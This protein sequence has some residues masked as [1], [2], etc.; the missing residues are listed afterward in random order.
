MNERGSLRAMVRLGQAGWA[1]MGAGPQSDVDG[2][3]TFSL[4]WLD[5]LRAR[6][7]RLT[8]EGVALFVPDEMRE[9]FVPAT[10]Y[11]YPFMQPDEDGNVLPD[12][13]R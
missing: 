9:T 12:A 5:Y 3:L 11:R 2:V 13:G 8:I 6:E 1:A 4:I 7:R 10:D